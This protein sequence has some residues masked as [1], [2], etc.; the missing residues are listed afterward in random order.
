MRIKFITLLANPDGVF[1]ANK[2]YDMPADVAKKLV[3]DGF[4]EAL[5]EVVAEEAPKKRGKKKAEE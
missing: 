2:E 3:K 5:E 4:A 1:D